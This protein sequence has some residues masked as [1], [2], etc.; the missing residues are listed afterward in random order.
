M[1][2]TSTV[3][4]RNFYSFLWHAAFLAFAQ[5]FMD[6]DTVIPALMVDAGGSAVQIGILTA[7]MLGGSSFTQLIYAPF[8][9][10]YQYKRKFL[11]LGINSRILALTGLAFLLFYSEML[12]ASNMI[13]FI[14]ILIS[15]FSFGGAFANVSYTDILGKSIHQ[16]DRKKFFSVRQV[17]T[18]FVLLGAAFL[19][20][21]VLGMSVY[22]ANYSFMFMIAFC[23]LLFASFGFWNIKEEIP[24]KM[25]VKSPGHFFQLV[26]SELRQNSKLKYFLGYINT[27]GISIGLLPFIILYAK[28]IQNPES[29]STGLF[30]LYKITGSVA[31]GFAL[32]FLS[33]HYKYRYLL[34]GGSLLSFSLPLLV[35]FSPG[36][37]LFIFIFLIG[38][39][40]YSTYSISMNGVLLEISGTSNRALYTGIVGA[41]NI[42][43]MLF[44]LLGGCG[45]SRHYG[46]EPFFYAYMLIILTS[47]FFVYKINC[48]R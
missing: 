27:M 26:K 3:S 45:L 41:G 30:L 2:L 37:P 35:L 17:V 11:L 48:R 16:S 18:G 31:T 8:I 32:F 38:G 19:A 7:I 43:P 23:A 13:L 14:F 39:I 22:P 15:V 10:N 12:N 24:S 46:F 36:T 20:K 9:S 40:I 29:A 4:K 47:F 5:V 44:P 28:E 33:K 1:E 34:Y 6:V 25:P 42:L 21:R